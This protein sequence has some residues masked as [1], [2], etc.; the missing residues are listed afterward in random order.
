MQRLLGLLLAVVLGLTVAPAGFGQGRVPPPPPEPEPVVVQPPANVPPPPGVMPTVVPLPPPP[1]DHAPLMVLPA[2]EPCRIGWFVDAEIGL[3]FLTL[4][5]FPDLP[6]VDPDATVAGGVRFGYRFAHG[7]AIRFNFAGLDATGN[8]DGFDGILGDVRVRSQI[9]NH[10]FDIDYVSAR[11]GAPEDWSAVWN[12]GFRFVDQTLETRLIGPLGGEVTGAN[13]FTGG[14]VHFGLEVAHGLQGGGLQ[15]FGRADGGIVFGEGQQTVRAEVAALDFG[16]AT[17]GPEQEPM[18]NLQLGVRWLPLHCDW[19]RI[20]AG[21]QYE[22]WW[23][24]TRGDNAD[25]AFF[26]R[27][28]FDAHGPFLRFELGY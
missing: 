21:Y 8:G 5:D 9:Q 16:V 17:E 23:M 6:T 27:L 1:P 25:D 20:V 2:T 11:L 15:L 4:K 12:I 13:D 22:R 24:Q 14:G 26:T 28:G 3:A 7:G 10:F 18:V 19:F